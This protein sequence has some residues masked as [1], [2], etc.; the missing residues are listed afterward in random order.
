VLEAA[1]EAG[2][3]T[4][5]KRDRTGLLISSDEMENGMIA[6][7]TTYHPNG[8]VHTISHY[9]NYQLH[10]SQMKYT[11]SGKPLMEMNW[12][13]GILDGSKII[14]RNGSVIAVVPFVNGK[15]EGTEFHYDDLGN[16]TAEITWRA[17]KKHGVSHLHAEEA[18]DTEWFF[19]G[20]SVEAEKFK[21]LDER[22]QIASELRNAEIL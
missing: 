16:L 5:I 13:D 10:G 17:D 15:K 18:T 14:Y 3:G 1:V 20:Q 6:G 9:H 12:K 22:D 19:R 2:A 11:A 7:R 4:R 8:N 21:T